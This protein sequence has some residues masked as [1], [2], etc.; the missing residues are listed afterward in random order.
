[1]RTLYKYLFNCHSF[2]LAPT[3]YE[4]QTFELTWIVP[5]D[6][7]ISLSLFSPTPNPCHKHGAYESQTGLFALF[8]LIVFLKIE[9]SKHVQFC[10]VGRLCCRW[11]SAERINAH[12]KIDLNVLTSFESLLVP[13]C[14]F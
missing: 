4:R 9:Y 1:M 7:F 6:L 5:N 12:S 10:M 3:E 14:I 13:V 11:Q 2:G 8:L